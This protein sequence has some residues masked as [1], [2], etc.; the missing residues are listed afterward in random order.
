MTMLL[1][2]VV[3]AIGILIVTTGYYYT[4]NPFGPESADSVDPILFL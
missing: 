2:G 3:E 4:P 1:K